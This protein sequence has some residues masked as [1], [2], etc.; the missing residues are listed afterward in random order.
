MDMK[1]TFLPE[2]GHEMVTFAHFR[3][4]I[5]WRTATQ[6]MVDADPTHPKTAA[7]RPK[8]SKLGTTAP[9]SGTGLTYRRRYDRVRTRK[10]GS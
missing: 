1:S 10:P 4:G 6:L 5:R 7:H 2:F 8:N 9:K 3:V